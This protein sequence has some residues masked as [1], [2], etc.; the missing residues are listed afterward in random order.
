LQRTRQSSAST[1]K[2]VSFP[3]NFRILNK[4]LLTEWGANY[5]VALKRRAPGARHITDKMP[6]NFLA[7]GLIYLMLPNAKIIHVKRSP[8]DTCLSCFTR[9]FRRKQQGHTYDLAELG[10]YY[11][12]YVRLMNHWRSVLPAGSFLEVQYEDIVADQALQARRLIE[13]CGLEWN[14][15]CLNF[16]K[17]QR[18]IRTASLTQVR[19]PIYTSSVERWRPYEKFLEPLLN[20][21]GDL[22]PNREHIGK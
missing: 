1:E 7:V 4:E 17:T 15:N 9:L 6:A 18:P 2:Q 21:L 8:M 19:Q 10:R 13:Y 5:V 11:A 12:D 16:H 20:A 14:D 3:N 22:V